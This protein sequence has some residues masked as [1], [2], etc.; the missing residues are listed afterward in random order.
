MNDDSER[1]LCQCLPV[2][3]GVNIG[4]YTHFLMNKLIKLKQILSFLNE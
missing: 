3:R 4:Y 1:I 2:K